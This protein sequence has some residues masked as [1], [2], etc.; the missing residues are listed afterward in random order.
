MSASG[1]RRAPGSAP[2]R[3]A[4]IAPPGAGER[5]AEIVAH[6]GRP[7]PPSLAAGM[8]RRLG[9]RLDDIRIHTDDRAAAA[10]DGIGAAAYTR[11]RHIAFAEGAFAPGTTDGMRLLAHELAHVAL[12]HGRVGSEGVLHR[13]EKP[14]LPG[15]HPDLAGIP[16][17]VL[18]SLYRQIE[19]G[20]HLYRRY[21]VRVAAEEGLA[22]ERVRS[23]EESGRPPAISDPPPIMTPEG[24]VSPQISI[25]RGDARPAALSLLTDRPA[26]V[27]ELSTLPADLADRF[28][29]LLAYQLINVA[30]ELMRRD[31]EFRREVLREAARRREGIRRWQER[32]ETPVVPEGATRSG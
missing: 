17:P 13:R 23:E 3:S 2:R 7:L 28:L 1:R 30:S 16:S 5:A 19:I 15:E 27:R 32:R 14:P 31:P 18:R 9:H 26:L 24:V 22:Q 6:P 20:P 11:G 25:I 8:G 29:E 12:D 21:L 4:T 10:A